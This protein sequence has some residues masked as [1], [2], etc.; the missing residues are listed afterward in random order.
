M[1]KILTWTANFRR[2]KTLTA[3]FFTAELF[4]NLARA[5]FFTAMSELSKWSDGRVAERPCV[6]DPLLI[7]QAASLAKLFPAAQFIYMVRD[8]RAQIPSQI[9]LHRK[10][11]SSQ[12][13]KSKK[14]YLD[15]WNEFNS[16]VHRQCVVSIGAQ[17]CLLVHY[18][19]LILDLNA[20]MLSVCEFLNITWTDHFRHHEQFIGSRIKVTPYE[21][22]TEQIKK[23]IYTESLFAWNT[24][25]DYADLGES[26]ENMSTMFNVFGYKS[27]ESGY[28]YLLRKKGGKN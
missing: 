13:T 1:N 16:D 12:T 8:P 14:S 28:T 18:E 9:Q 10:N 6:K 11:V 7:I 26:F 24:T 25:I 3:R 5:Y 21:P 4:D 2:E 22:S 19:E 20:T 27:H 15:K 23:P 17:R